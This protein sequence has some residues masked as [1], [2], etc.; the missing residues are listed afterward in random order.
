MRYEGEIDEIAA[1]HKRTE[2]LLA[3]CESLRT[4]LENIAILNDNALLYEHI[5]ELCVRVSDHV[6]AKQEA[7]KKKVRASMGGEILELMSDRIAAA[8]KDAR[9]RG[10]EEGHAE[11]LKAGRAEGLKEGRAEG[12]KTGR[13]EGH[14]EGLEEGR[15]EGREEGQ[16]DMAKRLR[17]LGVAEELIAQAL[18]SKDTRTA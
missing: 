9:E 15:E 1:S 4:R 6:L 10:R 16:S 14:E 12:L 3:E 11:G 7:L 5:V 17:A 8:E 18:D 2:Q 13:A